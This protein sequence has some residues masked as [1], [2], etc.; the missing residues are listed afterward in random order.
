MVFITFK[1]NSSSDINIKN[2]TINVILI[3]ILINT[4]KNGWVIIKILY[5]NHNNKYYYFNNTY[6]VLHFK[7]NIER[8]TVK[9]KKM[10][11]M[12]IKKIKKKQKYK[13]DD[14]DKKM[15]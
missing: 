4:L 5:Y 11:K 14:N 15:N 3:F 6:W 12:E 8:K 10:V 9:I 13:D 7:L 2:N 1:L